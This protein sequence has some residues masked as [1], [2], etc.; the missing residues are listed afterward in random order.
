MEYIKTHKLAVFALLLWL[1]CVAIG[2]YNLL[3]SRDVGVLWALTT[4]LVSAFILPA[5][6]A[7]I[8]AIFSRFRN[9][10]TV[11]WVFMI[12]SGLFLWTVYT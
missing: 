2:T 11:S 10:K 3:V 5:F 8:L 6:I 12:W 7:G 4:A 9:L 1:G